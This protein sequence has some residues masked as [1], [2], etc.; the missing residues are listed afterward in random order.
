M[1]LILDLHIIGN[2]FS[3]AVPVLPPLFPLLLSKT[4]IKHAGR[5]QR[6]SVCVVGDLL[7][8]LS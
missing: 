5:Q 2:N 3:M 8:V 7:R 1:Y 4:T 6:L